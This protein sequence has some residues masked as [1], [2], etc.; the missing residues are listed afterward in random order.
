MELTIRIDEFR[1]LGE[2][3]LGLGKIETTGHTTQLN[4]TGE[5]AQLVTY[6]RGKAILSRDFP[7]HAEGLAAAALS[8]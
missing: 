6:S 8:E 3:V 5:I 2:S 1:D 4:F 7:S